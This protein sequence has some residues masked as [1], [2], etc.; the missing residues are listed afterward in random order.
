MSRLS[1][2]RP[3]KEREQ[4]VATELASRTEVRITALRSLWP[5]LIWLMIAGL[6]KGQEPAAGI[7]LEPER[8]HLGTVKSG[9]LFDRRIKIVNRSRHQIDI[10]DVKASCGCVH[11][12][13]TA[14]SLAPGAESTLEVRIN[15][16]TNSPGLQAWRVV[17]SGRSPAGPLS[18]ELMILAEVKQ[19]LTL[20][21]TALTLYLGDR[22]AHA[23]L[24]LTDQRPRPLQV[25]SAAATIPQVQV[26]PVASASGSAV[27]EIT[28]VPDLPPGRHEAQIILTTNDAIY[29]SLLVPVSIIKR[30]HQRWW[31]SPSELR[32]D[33]NT[34]WQRRLTV[35]DRQGENVVVHKVDAT[36]PGVTGRVLSQKGSS[37]TLEVTAR[38]TG[39]PQLGELVLYV[40]DTNQPIRIPVRVL[41]DE[42][43]R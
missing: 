25:N 1:P 23:R 41:A 39:V 9:Q 40:A 28:I 10:D 21:P 5:A 43:R 17:L 30:S 22:P 36:I 11:A 24:T 12:R 37:V 19:E 42:R 16:L 2:G 7:M 14:T 31:T 26:T 38:A 35:Q 27:F 3:V 33:A 8:I 6:A 18:A 29:P 34:G 20:T 15:T 32:F 4:T 13:L